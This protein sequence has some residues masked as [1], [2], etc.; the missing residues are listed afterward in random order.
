MSKHRALLAPGHLLA[1]G[2]TPLDLVGQSGA[3]WV[4][5]CVPRSS[6]AAAAFLPVPPPGT[7]SASR[8]PAVTD[9]C[10]RC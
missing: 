4:R 2:R 6:Q 9:G 5:I 3:G 7:L 10:A 1:H 8:L